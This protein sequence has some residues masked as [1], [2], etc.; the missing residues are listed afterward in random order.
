MFYILL[1]RTQGMPI[2]FLTLFSCSS[3]RRYPVDINLIFSYN[4]ATKNYSYSKRLCQGVYTCASFGELVFD[5]LAS[6]ALFHPYI[7]H[8][9]YLDTQNQI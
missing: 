9:S 3:E 8:P 5:Y 6:A 4:I 2:L 7:K 1:L